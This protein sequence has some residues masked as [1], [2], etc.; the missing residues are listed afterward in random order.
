MLNRLTTLQRPFHRLE[1]SA[2]YG[3]EE[4]KKKKHFFVNVNGRGQLP[5]LAFCVTLLRRRAAKKKVKNIDAAFIHL[6]F[7]R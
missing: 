1:R 3:G 7:Y 6:L 2:E 5:S 4:S